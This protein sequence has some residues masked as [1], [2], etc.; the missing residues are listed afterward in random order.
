MN[1]TIT[2]QDLR[3]RCAALV[4]AGRTDRV[5]AALHVVGA[6]KLQEIDR[7]DYLLF[8]Q[9]LQRAGGK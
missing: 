7:R 2:L 9:M 8:D 3:N 4:Y 1:S 6:E 5:K